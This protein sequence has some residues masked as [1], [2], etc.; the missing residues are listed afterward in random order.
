MSCMHERLRKVV[1]ITFCLSPIYISKAM[2]TSTLLERCNEAQR[3]S[4]TNYFLNV[5]SIL[6][7]ILLSLFNSLQSFQGLK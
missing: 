3:T 4:S 2:G 5:F 6:L 7:F 1:F